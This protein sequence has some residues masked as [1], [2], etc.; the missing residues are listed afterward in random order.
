VVTLYIAGLDREG[1][2]AWIAGGGGFATSNWAQ[3]KCSFHSGNNE[4]IGV[5]CWY[6]AP[7]TIWLDDAGVRPVVEADYKAEQIQDGSFEQ[8]APGAPPIQ[9]M[10]GSPGRVKGIKD[11]TAASI[12]VDDTT[13]HQGKQSVKISM[14]GNQ[15]F[16]LHYGSILIKPGEDY[17]LTFWVKSDGPEVPF[18]CIA[19]AEIGPDRKHWYLRRT[20]KATPKWK[21][22]EFLIHIP[23]PGEPMYWEGRFRGGFHLQGSWEGKGTLWIDDMSYRV[24]VVEW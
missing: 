4:T 12:L 11:K 19:S 2:S 10:D 6:R 3:V 18:E 22:C 14:A 5:G 8:A 24:A 21:E 15:V 1:K 16:V 13:A 9:L 7:G 23:G 17:Y 20:F